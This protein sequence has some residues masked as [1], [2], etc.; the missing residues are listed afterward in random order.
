MWQTRNSSLGRILV[1]PQ[2]PDGYSVFTTTLDFEG[3][4]NPEIAAQISALIETEFGIT[5]TLATCAQI[6]S[7]TARRAS[8]TSVWS[9][10]DACDAL[11]TTEVNVALG[12]KVADCLPVT[13]IDPVHRVVANVHSGWRGAV[14]RITTGTLDAVQHETSFDPATALVYL[15]PSIRSCCFEVGED[16]AVQFDE[17][18]L[19]RSRTKVHVDLIAFTVGLLE[20]R[21]ITCDRISDSG[22]CTRCEGSILHSYRRVG[23]GG[24]RNLQIVAQ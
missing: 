12:I 16:V 23:P 4:L 1:P 10:C 24:G 20:A 15:G 22:I 8:R 17:R 19:D 9:E 18:F 2:L 6:H 11:W 7:A 3:K 13:M 5:A 14:Q 21:G